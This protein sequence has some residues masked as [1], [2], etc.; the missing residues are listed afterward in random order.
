M[1]NQRKPITAPCPYCGKENEISFLNYKNYFT[2]RNGKKKLFCN[3]NCYEKYK[4]Q[5]FVKEY[6]RNKIYKFILDGKPFY[7][8]YFEAAYGFTS[9]EDCKK[10]IDSKCAVV[11]LN[12]Y[13]TMINYLFK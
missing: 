10:R 12:V 4:E 11:D 3:E 8:P 1:N 7:V 6:H 9:L 2:V 5:F 13:R